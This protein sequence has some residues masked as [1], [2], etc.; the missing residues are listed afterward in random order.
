M[1]RLVDPSMN[2]FMHLIS[3][4]TIEDSDS[5][6]IEF[7]DSNGQVACYDDDDDSDKEDSTRLK[8]NSPRPLMQVMYIQMEFCEKCTLR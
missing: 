3:R 2:N 7:V 1:E 4:P 6:G 8:A 5:D